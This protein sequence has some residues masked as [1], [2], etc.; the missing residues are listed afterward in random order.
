MHPTIKFTHSYNLT[1]RSTT[2]L[3]TCVTIDETNQISTDL[4]KKETDRVQYLLPTSCHP[5]HIFNNIPYSLALRLVRICSKEDSLT[6]RM[7]E[8]ETML[9][10]REYNRNVVRAAIAKAMSI[11]RE[12][13]L[14]RVI[15]V[16]N[17][18]PIFV[19]TYNPALPNVVL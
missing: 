2:F 3:D 12:E 8:L 14:K 11:P 7:T 13:A 4:Y 16:K 15:K 6:Q 18:R 10:S 19:L 9:V 5:S 17:E 1:T